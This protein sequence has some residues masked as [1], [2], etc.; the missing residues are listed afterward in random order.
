[1]PLCRLHFQTLSALDPDTVFPL[2][3]SEVTV[4]FNRSYFLC[5]LV[6]KCWRERLLAALHSW[7][8]ILWKGHRGQMA[9]S[10]PVWV[11]QSH[12][13]NVCPLS[14][15]RVEDAAVTAVL[16]S[17]KHWSWN[18]NWHFAFL[19]CLFFCLTQI[20]LCCF[21]MQK[22]AFAEFQYFSSADS[23]TCSHPPLALSPAPC[24]F[25]YVDA[26]HYRCL[27]TLPLN[28]PSLEWL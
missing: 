24:G 25:F 15:Q 26:T 8:S 4:H 19:S 13:T 14:Q 18:L 3:R 9:F 22:K 16:I 17:E 21:F 20:T 1:M 11:K 28:V 6:G 10:Q 2:P 23:E 12:D 27:T 5:A 7:E